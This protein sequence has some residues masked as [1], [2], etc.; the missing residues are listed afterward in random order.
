MNENGVLGKEKARYPVMLKMLETCQ[1]SIPHEI[2]KEAIGIFSYLDNVV[3]NKDPMDVGV[4]GKEVFRNTG[5]SHEGN[6][7]ATYLT[8]S[9]QISLGK[10]GIEEIQAR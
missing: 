1:N 7:R 3:W 2:Y 5:T 10:I 8:H 9:A 4:N 6:Q